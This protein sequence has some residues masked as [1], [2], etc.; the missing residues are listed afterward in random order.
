MTVVIDGTTGITSP[1]GQFN[2]ASTFGFKNRIINGAMVIDQRNAG[3]SVSI[4]SNYTIGYAVDRFQALKNGAG[5][6]TVQQSS[7]A[8]SGYTNSLVATV[9]T[10]DTSI[11]VDDFALVSQ[12]IEGY[13]VADLGF[14]AAGAATVTL[15]FWVRS[16][17]TGTYGAAIVNGDGNRS[18]V[19][20]YTI[21]AANTWEQKTITVTGDTSGTWLK[22]NGSGMVARF[23]LTA[24]SNFQ[25]AAGSWGT[26]NAMASSSNVNWLGTVGN[27]FYITGVQLE[28]GSTATSFDYRPYGTEL[29]LCQRYFWMIDPSGSQPTPF[30]IGWYNSKSRIPLPCPVMMRSSPSVT[31]S[32]TAAA[33]FFSTNDDVSYT[34]FTFSYASGLQQKSLTCV[35]MTLTADTSYGSGVMY[36]QSNRTLSISSEL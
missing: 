34:N 5:V 6:F 11:A 3:A 29:A 23:G 18:Y 2:S 22:T 20:N 36:I 35:F 13:N 4:S 32:G 25:Q 30:I 15:S 24:G 27:N 8:P 19:T 14:G 31:F 21:N 16:N 7:T 28:K 1:S 33:A 26:G 12:V 10:A 9:T 17:L